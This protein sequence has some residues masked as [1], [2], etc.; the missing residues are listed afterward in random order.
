MGL[1]SCS[2]IMGEPRGTSP[3]ADDCASQFCMHAPTVLHCYRNLCEA[4]GVLTNSC[5]PHVNEVSHK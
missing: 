4:N 2:E 5:C 3:E 1:K